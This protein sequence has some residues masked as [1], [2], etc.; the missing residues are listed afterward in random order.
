MPAGE[1]PRETNDEVGEGNGEVDRF[2][3][4]LRVYR[5]QIVSITAP[6]GNKIRPLTPHVLEFG[7]KVLVLD[8]DRRRYVSVA[9]CGLGSS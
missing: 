6:S 5:A 1:T 4:D 8:A 2:N 7:S 9:P 3:G